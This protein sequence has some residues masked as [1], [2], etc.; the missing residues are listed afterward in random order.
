M[1]ASIT[2]LG[3]GSAAPTLERNQA[4]QLLKMQGRLFLIDCGEGTQM[5]I[6]KYGQRILS[7]DGIFIS[8]MHGD[9][10]FGLPGLLF[11]MH[12]FARKKPLTVY[13]PPELNDIVDLAL[14]ASNSTLAY[15]LHFVALTAGVQEVII[16]DHRL[17]VNTIVMNHRI[18]CWGFVFREKPGMR[19]IIMQNMPSEKIAVSWYQRIKEG[20]DL[21]MDDGTIIPNGQLTTSPPNPFSYTYCGDTLFERQLAQQIGT[22]TWLYHEATYQNDHAASAAEKFHST[23]AQAAELAVLTNSE[24]LII[25]HFSVRYKE[26]EGFRTEA[27]QIFRETILAEDGLNLEYP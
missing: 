8:H 10:Y 2:I 21:V 6:R 17:E 5:Q 4:A 19:N 24:K 11:S 16:D 7:I 18:P 9:H 23:A 12:L 25:G 1:S 26:Y 20:E 22:T 15:P 27:M 3:S 13:G 14:K